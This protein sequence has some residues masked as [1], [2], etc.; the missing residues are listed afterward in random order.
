MY[1]LRLDDSNDLKFHSTSLGL[2]KINAR[3]NYIEHTM[4]KLITYTSGKVSAILLS[5]FSID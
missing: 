4:M 5:T 2:L 3:S 1:R